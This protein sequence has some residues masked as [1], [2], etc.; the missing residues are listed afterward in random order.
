[1]PETWRDQMRRYKDRWIITVAAILSV[2]FHIALIVVFMRFS[3]SAALPEPPKTMDIDLA[4]L[5][6]AKLQALAQ[7]ANP[8]KPQRLDFRHLQGNEQVPQRADAYGF[9]NNDAGQST[10]REDRRVQE[11]QRATGPRGPSRGAGAAAGSPA[12]RRA[13]AQGGRELPPIPQIGEGVG[14]PRDNREPEREAGQG[15]LRNVDQMLAR[16]GMARPEG[17]GG[18]DGGVDEYNPNVGSGGRSLSISTREYRYMSYFAHMKEKI[19]MAWLYPQEAQRTGQQGTTTLQFTVLHSGQVR[20][21]KV[22]RTSGFPLL[23]RYAMKAVQE[24]HFNPM[25]S[26]WPEPQLVITA[27]FIYQLI[28]SRAV[29]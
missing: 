10:H 12:E 1:M 23:D 29:Q 20:D 21:V 2:L 7:Q 28:G 16:A 17:G 25:P 22:L 24:A 5:D 4:N 15:P 3:F 8:D 27:N 13:G 11:I 14:E 9:Q 18:G 19:E 26:A 6:A